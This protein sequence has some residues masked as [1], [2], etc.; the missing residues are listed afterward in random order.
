VLSAKAA[1]GSRPPHTEQG[2]NKK[3]P[4]LN[5]LQNMCAFYASRSHVFLMVFSLRRLKRAGT[6]RSRRG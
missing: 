4:I 3:K 6:D 1:V 5:G 2:K